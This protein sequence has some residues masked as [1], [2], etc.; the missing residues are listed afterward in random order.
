MT[1][2]LTA[3]ATLIDTLPLE[4]L[5]AD[6]VENPAIGRPA[7][8]DGLTARIEEILMDAGGT[9]ISTHELA[10]TIADAV[11]TALPG[12]VPDLDFQHVGQHPP[13]YDAGMLPTGWYKIRYDSERGWLVLRGH[14]LI[15][16]ETDTT[17]TAIDAANAHHR[18][19]IMLVMGVEI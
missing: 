13:Q 2:D 3:P 5:A 16:A 17:E 4:T 11:I 9:P 18:A 7:S 12:M 15:V 19:Q 8:D 10:S 14:A 6:V 1:D